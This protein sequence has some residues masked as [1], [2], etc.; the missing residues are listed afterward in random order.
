MKKKMVLSTV[1]GT[2][3][4]AVGGSVVV[5]NTASKSVEKWRTM[6]DKHLALFLLMNEWMKT[7]QEGKC[8]KEYFEKNNYKSVAIYGLSYVGERLLDELKDCEVDVKYVIDKNADSIYTDM[9]IYLPDEELPEA[10]VI[11]VTA[12]YFF[13]EIY[14]KLVDKVGCPI[15]SFEDILYE[16]S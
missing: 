5:G 14:N 3:V 15:V 12:V 11:V 6:S 8:I 10:D 4:G 9:D 7:K 13:D 2:I 16:L 1:L